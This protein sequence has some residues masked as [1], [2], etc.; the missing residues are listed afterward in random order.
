[1]SHMNETDLVAD[2][3]W[4]YATKKFDSSKGIPDSTWESL[5]KAAS[6]TPTSFGLEPYRL[7]DV[8]DP[9]VREALKAVS[10]GQTQVVDAA[11]Y[12]VFAI[13]KPFGTAHIDAFVERT[14]RA[15][16]VARE[17]LD[18]FRKMMVATLVDGPR[19]ANIVNWAAH[20]AY[21]A[22][23]NMMAA[24]AH[25]GVD[26]CPLEGL[27]PEKYDEILGLKEKGLATVCAVAFGHRAEGDKYATL[28]KVRKTLDELFI[29]V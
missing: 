7:I 26:S 29:T 17:S 5:R 20:Q 9:K 15:R 18:G 27:D 8:R 3:S 22:L 21:I 16:G 11:R 1:M 13:E 14:M 23:G 28:P 25:L 4:R 24:G 2:L 10:W 12:V 19:S 6:L